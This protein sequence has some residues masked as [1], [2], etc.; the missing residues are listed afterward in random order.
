MKSGDKFDISFLSLDKKGKHKWARYGFT[1]ESL[2]TTT[3]TKLFHAGVS[4]KMMCHILQRPASGTLSKL[5]QGG[6][7]RMS[8]T[9]EYTAHGCTYKGLSD[10]SIREMVEALSKLEGHIPCTSRVVKVEYDIE[11]VL[12]DIHIESG[13]IAHASPKPVGLQESET[14]L[15]NDDWANRLPPRGINITIPPEELRKHLMKISDADGARV[16]LDATS[17]FS[18]IEK[19]V[20]AHEVDALSYT[21][22]VNNEGPKVSLQQMKE[23]YEKLTSE[24]EAICTSRAALFP[25]VLSDFGFVADEIHISPA[26]LRNIP[27]K[28]ITMSIKSIETKTFINGADAVHLTDAELFK[29]IKATE[30]EIKD[31]Q[32]IDHKPEKLKKQIEEKNDLLKKLVDYVDA[33]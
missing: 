13:G 27:F 8:T 28:G 23:A 26:H 17:D 16:I 24:G 7:V 20:L 9:G 1:W 2:E 12:R 14:I 11:G 5:A 21:I 15:R 30:N 25:S 31:L 32:G 22:N 19:R 3:L 29:M 18:E 10:T 33:R 4:L 6:Y